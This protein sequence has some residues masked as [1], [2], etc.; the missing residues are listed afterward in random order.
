MSNIEWTNQTWNPVTGCSKVSAGCKNCYAI[1]MSH[2]LQAMPNMQNRYGG[3]T[4]KRENGTINFT[5]KVMCHE[6]V[7]NKPYKWRKSRKVFVNSMSDLFHENVPVSFIKKV[8]K[9]MNDTPH[10][11]YQVLTKRP[12]RLKEINNLVNWS[13]NIW[14]G[15]SCENQ[16]TTNS[17]IPLL[18]TTDAKVRFVSFEP[19]L[20]EIDL[21]HDDVIDCFVKYG[22]NMTEEHATNLVNWAIVGGESGHNARPIS[23]DDIVDLVDNLQEFGVAT[24]VKQLGTQLA[25]EL[26]MSTKKGNVFSE[27]PKNLQVREYPKL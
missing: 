27:F 24:F 13:R 11:T 7:L 18:C 21:Y 5:G 25:K 10:H 1:T 26:K 8:F 17:R 19:L 20:G 23:L 2:R 16:E 15:V 22:K 3:T 9:V 4:K 14:L 12:E 6:A